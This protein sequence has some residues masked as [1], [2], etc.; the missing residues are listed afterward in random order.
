MKGRPFDNLV[1]MLQS[2]DWMPNNS[3]D[4]GADLNTLVAL[5]K[6]AQV[7]ITDSLSQQNINDLVEYSSVMSRELCLS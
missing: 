4:A 3:L 1:K 7:P 6:Q 2:W 5:P